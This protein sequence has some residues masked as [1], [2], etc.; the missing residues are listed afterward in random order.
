M[1]K[2]D[3]ILCIGGPLHGTR[4]SDSGYCLLAY[5]SYEPPVTY[6]PPVIKPLCHGPGYRRLPAKV[7][8][9][10]ER[11]KIKPIRYDKRRIFDFNHTPPQTVT[12]Y[13]LSSLTNSEIATYY[14][15]LSK[16]NH[17]EKT[18]IFPKE[19]QAGEAVQGLPVL[20]QRQ[21]RPDL[22]P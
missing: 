3:P 4:T 18:Q 8:P 12:L 13:A 7:Y 6:I 22:R 16:E 10:V 15:L 9:K 14:Y 5:E 11:P 17:E 21:H 1:S 2:S 19:E 20:R